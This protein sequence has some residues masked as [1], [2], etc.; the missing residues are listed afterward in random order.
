MCSF[1]LR[2]RGF[3]LEGTSGK[4]KKPLVLM[5]CVSRAWVWKTYTNA[6]GIVIMASTINNHLHESCQ[7]SNNQPM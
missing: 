7:R 1:S 4:T 2:K 3:F 5:S 6:I